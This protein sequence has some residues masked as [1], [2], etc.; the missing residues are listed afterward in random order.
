MPEDARGGRVWG[1]ANK[2]PTGVQQRYLRKLGRLAGVRVV[3][4][5]TRGKAALL[6]G[7]LEEVI[8]VRKGGDDAA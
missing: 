5:P 6:A 3:I 8:R 7:E 2:R 1:N 4:P